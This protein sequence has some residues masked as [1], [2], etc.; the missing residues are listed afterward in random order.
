MLIAGLRVH[1]LRKLEISLI[2][3]PINRQT[4]IVNKII[5][6]AYIALEFSKPRPSTIP[7]LS[8]LLVMKNILNRRYNVRKV[9][10]SWNSIGRIEISRRIVG[11][12]K[13]SFN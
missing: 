11:I 2:G 3:S 1:Q 10:V 13:F 6:T 5:I 12:F 8:L 7:A 9:I 4:A